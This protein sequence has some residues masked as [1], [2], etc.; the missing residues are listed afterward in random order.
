MNVVE[1][2]QHGVTPRLCQDLHIV[3]EQNEQRAT[4]SIGIPR[5]LFPDCTDPTRLFSKTINAESV[6]A[7]LWAHR[8]LRYTVQHLNSPGITL[9]SNFERVRKCFVD[10]GCE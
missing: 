9:L 6:N 1:L 4:T 5:K 8:I 2:I 10:S 3:P 7:V